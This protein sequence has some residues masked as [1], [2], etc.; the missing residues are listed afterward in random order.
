MGDASPNEPDTWDDSILHPWRSIAY[1]MVDKL[2][3]AALCLLFALHVINQPS[4]SVVDASHAMKD[5]ETLRSS[6]WQISYHLYYLLRHA[7]DFL[8]NLTP[9]ERF[10]SLQQIK[11]LLKRRAQG[12]SY[13][14]CSPSAESSNGGEVQEIGLSSHK[15]VVKDETE[16]SEVSLESQPPGLR[17]PT[18]MG[19]QIG[20]YG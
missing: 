18:T 8:D 16:K 12:V 3:G 17:M 20:E 15:S 19:M 5:M 1:K 11:P 2:N 10:Y 4:Q 13:Q 14:K 6:T 9:V 7:Q